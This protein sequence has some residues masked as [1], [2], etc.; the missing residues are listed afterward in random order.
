M[1]GIRILK[2]FGAERLQ[3]KRLDAAADGVLKQ[4]LRAAKLRA[5]FMP[6]I[7]LLPTLSLVAIIWYGGHL[8]LDGQLEIG[9]ILAYNLYVLMLIWPLRM[10]GMLVAQSSRICSGWSDS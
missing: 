8:V 6:L 9:D 7:D 4:A 3:V 5:G 1:S 2:G 10:V